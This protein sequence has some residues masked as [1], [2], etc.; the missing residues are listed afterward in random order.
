MWAHVCQD[1]YGFWFVTLERL[2]GNLVLMAHATTFDQ[3]EHEAS[4]VTDQIRVDA[5]PH[6]D[7]PVGGIVPGYH[8]PEPRRAYI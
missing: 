8:P 1:E 2:D 3:A 7:F 6:R 5:L 4:H